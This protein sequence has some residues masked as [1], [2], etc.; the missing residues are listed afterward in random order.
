MR[1]RHC[2]L[3][4]V[5]FVT[6]TA[7][8]GHAQRVATPYLGINISGDV[9]KRK[10][11]PGGSISYFGGLLGFEL[12]FERYQH[13]F[14]DEDMVNLVPSSCVNCSDPGT[15]FDT[16]AVSFMGNL[17]API[18]IQGATK[19]RPY[20]TAGLGVIR[21]WLDSTVDRFDTHQNNLGFNVGGGVMYSLSKHM[22][23]RGDLRYFRALVDEDK[24]EGAFTRDYGFW[25]T[26]IGFT[27]GFP[28]VK[29]SASAGGP[30]PPA[31]VP[32]RA[33]GS[34]KM[35]EMAPSRPDTGSASLIEGCHT[36]RCRFV[37]PME[38]GIEAGGRPW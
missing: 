32:W 10:G 31:A 21:A 23:L 18:N 1:V 20:G 24:R 27:L 7:A 19:W 9:E 3:L 28:A 12:D 35:A 29:E 6:S 36:G 15:D 14:K 34:G 16:D 25:R 8:P 22:G 37:F 2:I 33:A 26:T 4:T 5:L 38:S 11:G 17:V 30:I 13:F